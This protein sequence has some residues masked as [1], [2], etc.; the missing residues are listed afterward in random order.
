M[1]S[2][3]EYRSSIF[4]RSNVNPIASLGNCTLLCLILVG[5]CQSFNILTEGL[6]E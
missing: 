5:Y 4:F 3:P 1:L 2:D 6:F